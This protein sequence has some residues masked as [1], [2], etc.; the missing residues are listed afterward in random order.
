MGIGSALCP[1]NLWWGKGNVDISLGDSQAKFWRGKLS[2][3]V[4]GI[5]TPLIGGLLVLG[6]DRQAGDQYRYLTLAT[7]SG[8]GNGHNKDNTVTMAQ[9]PS[10]G[11][12]PYC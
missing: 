1:K 7:T 3:N 4:I 11:A 12:P 5:Y 9:K 6:H 2:A 10:N 8:A